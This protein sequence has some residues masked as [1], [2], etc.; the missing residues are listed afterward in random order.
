M[1]RRQRPAEPPEPPSLLGRLINS[2]L[3]IAAAL[4]LIATLAVAV[5][6]AL[7]VRMPGSSH[8][9]ALPALSAEQDALRVG[10]E[11]DVRQLAGTIGARS[12]THREGLAQAADYLV[13]RLRAIGYV[14]QREPYGYGDQRYE[15]IIAER[16][17]G[18]LEAGVIVIGAHYDGEGDVP[19]ANDNAS[20]VAAL[21][22]L[23]ERFASRTPLITVR[24]AFFAGEENPCFG[25]A[26]MGSL[27]HARASKAAGERLIGMISLETIGW[28]DDAAGSQRYP[29]PLAAL[30]PDRGDFIAFVGNLDSASLVRML[31][32]DFRSHVAFP[33]QGA[34]LP[35]DVPGVGWSDHWAFWQVGCPAV[36]ITDT[37]PFRY[38]HYHRLTDTPDKLDYARMARVVDGLD[39]VLQ[40][41][42]EGR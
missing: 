3:R 35:E 32:G 21:L 36:M 42:A 5:G 11:A 12:P 30:Y 18:P 26:C 41:W 9:G 23:A 16:V 34:A 33:S 38:P 29:Q 25:K 7:C 17:G 19:A 28:Y 31:I 14:P 15:N 24:F 40:R 4:V 2:V 22:A 10:L 37:A 1:N 39:G 8:R 6:W 13:K 20:G 27:V